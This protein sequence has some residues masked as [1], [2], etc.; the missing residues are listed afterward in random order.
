MT[1]VQVNVIGATRSELGEDAPNRLRNGDRVVVRTPA[2]ILATLDEDGTT[3][4]LV[5]MPEMIPL[6]G[7]EFVVHARA[8]RLCDA[9]N[10][11]TRKM[12]NAVMLAGS[13]CDGSAHDGCQA[14]C[15]LFWNEAW[16]RPAGEPHSTAPA[17]T[18]SAAEEAELRQRVS[19][20]THPTGD[21][22]VVRY[23]CQ[24]TEM[25]EASYRVSN[26]DPRVYWNEYSSGNVSFRNF[27]RVMSHALVLQ[28]GSKL[29][30]VNTPPL[31]GTTSKTPPSPPPLDLQPGEWVRVRSA[32][33]VRATL[34]ERG[35]N[36]GLWFDREMMMLCGKVFQVRGRISRII[37]EKDKAMINLSNDCIILENAVCKSEY[38][39]SRWFCPRQA[40]P[41]WR[42]CWLE[43]VPAPEPAG[44]A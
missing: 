43:R 4:G 38:S 34:N 19:R 30:L 33:D 16:L 17:G 35:S 3:N 21:D 36:R 25:N 22:G 32:D 9:V 26:K 15:L 5:F 39:I 12:P 11:R 28:P 44:D 7:R 29:G 8:D 6:C 37:S 42:E 24:A 18:D 31:R 40:Y 1:D 14:Q 13:R 27:A 10:G 41:F 2:E 23:R 20:I